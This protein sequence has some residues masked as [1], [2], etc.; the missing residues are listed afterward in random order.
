M[1]PSLAILPLMRTAIDQITPESSSY[2]Y[3]SFSILNL[4]IVNPLSPSSL[5]LTAYLLWIQEAQPAE[6]EVLHM[7]LPNWPLTLL[8]NP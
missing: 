4:S 5:I 1:P 2:L 3:L 8:Q 6:S 7:I